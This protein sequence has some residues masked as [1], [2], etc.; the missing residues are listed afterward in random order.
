MTKYLRIQSS[1]SKLR[2]LFV[3]LLSLFSAQVMAQG[4]VLSVGVESSRPIAEVVRTLGIRHSVVIT[5]EDPK[6]EANP[7]VMQ[8]R[9]SYSVLPSTNAP[10]NF[11]ATLEAVLSAAEAVSSP[12][13]FRIERAGNVFHVVPNQ[14]RA[15]SGEWIDQR[16]V[17][18]ANIS[19]TVDEQRGSNALEVLEAIC[20]QL[21]TV[22]GTRV[23]LGNVPGIMLLNSKVTISVSN[24]RARDV[25]RDTLQAVDA[26]LTW[27][28]L[29]NP[30]VD[31]Y[32]LNI[33]A[34][35]NPTDAAIEKPIEANRPPIEQGAPFLRSPQSAQ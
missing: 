24:Q 8:L 6:R 5:Y 31:W 17:L 1:N 33:A 14:I 7:R 15:P 11:A 35:V 23:E 2:I 30:E 18:D 10:M 12:E 29:Y 28:L 25:L 9:T 20:D 13:R 19:Y 34:V 4:G 21:T 32:L 26:R 16:P 22:G 3:T 27:R